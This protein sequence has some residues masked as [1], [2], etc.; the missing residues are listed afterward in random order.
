MLDL[1]KIYSLSA[2]SDD[3]KALHLQTKNKDIIHKIDML[4]YGQKAELSSMPIEFIYLCG[5][6]AFDL[7]SCGFSHIYLISEKVVNLLV[8]ENVTGWDSYEVKAYDKEGYLLEGY[9]GLS[10]TGKCGPIKNEL[11]KKELMP[12]R[13]PWANS[14]SAYIGLYFDP[15]TWDGSDVFSPGETHHIFTSEKVKLLFE[16]QHVS[17]VFFTPISKMENLS[18]SF[19]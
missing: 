15:E 13:V 8:K 7:I 3:R 2:N 6:K 16:N 19:L 1:N 12:P 9:R 14:Y 4:F 11:S 17:S 10:I 5:S 18:S